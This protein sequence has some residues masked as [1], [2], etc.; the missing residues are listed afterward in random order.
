[1]VHRMAGLPLPTLAGRWPTSA[2]RA[3]TLVRRWQWLA[4]MAVLVTVGAPLAVHGLAR[5]QEWALPFVPAACGVGAF[6]GVALGAAS[7]LAASW[8][9]C[10]RRAWCLD[11]NGARGGHVSS[12]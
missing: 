10:V 6:M 11:R 1:V 5:A 3:R 4:L 8:M 2:H 7:V 9:G 12:V